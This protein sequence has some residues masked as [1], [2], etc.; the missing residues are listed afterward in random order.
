MDVQHARCAG[1]DIH[2]KSI[3]VCVLIRETGQREQKNL[4]EFGT[5]TAEILAC[6]DWLNELGVTH[7]AMESTGVYFALSSALIRR[8][9]VP[10]ALG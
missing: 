4:R 5:T 1:I 6:V 8:V 10:L 7:V 2:K 3:T 9:E